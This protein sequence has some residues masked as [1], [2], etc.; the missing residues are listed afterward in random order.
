MCAECIVKQRVV[1]LSRVEHK[2][3]RS[4]ATCHPPILPDPRNAEVVARNVRK[5][6]QRC[7]RILFLRDRLENLSRRLIYTEHDRQS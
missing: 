6:N 1:C 5:E 7:N 3:D 4:L 2:D